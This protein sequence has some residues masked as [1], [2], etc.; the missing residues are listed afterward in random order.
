M[1]VQFSQAPYQLSKNIITL[2]VSP[3]LPLSVSVSPTKEIN[4]CDSLHNNGG[5]THVSDS[6]DEILY[7]IAGAGVI[8]TQ[9]DTPY[10]SVYLNI[11]RNTPID[12][13]QSPNGELRIKYP[14][15]NNGGYTVNMTREQAIMKIEKSLRE[16]AN[17]Q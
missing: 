8:M 13:W 15:H 17:L 6:V 9:F 10:G 1:I 14:T 3:S 7:K 2:M 5:Y 16:Y 4:I 12:I 11:N